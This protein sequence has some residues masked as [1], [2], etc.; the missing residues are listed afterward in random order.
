[1]FAVCEAK[2][3]FKECKE[4]KG[5]CICEKT[6]IKCPYLCAYTVAEEK[7]EKTERDSDGLRYKQKSNEKAQSGRIK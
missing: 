2:K 5:M 3:T 1:M 6:K 4:V 7:I